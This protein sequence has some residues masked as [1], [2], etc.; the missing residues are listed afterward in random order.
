MTTKM[1]IVVPVYNAQEWVK[2]CIDSIATQQHKDFECVI[3]NDCSADRTGDVLSS[4]TLDSRFKIQHNEKNVGALANIVR[5]FKVLDYKSEPESVLMAIDG[6]DKLA[7]PTSLDVINKVYTKM[8]DCLLTYG[9]YT[10]WPSGAPGICERF[11]QEVIASRSYR[12]H[13]RFVTSHLR[14]FKSKLWNQLGDSELVDPRSGKYY[15]VTWDMA[16]MMPMM[17]MAGDRFVFVEQVL[18]LYNRVNPISDGYVREREQWDANQF[19]RSLPRKEYVE[20]V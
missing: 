5:G 16:F 15:T 8:P 1:K 6:D 7:T 12:S 9:N 10:D 20:S 3:I 18:Y 4:L 14:T 11:P 19:I 17:E 13:P 2:D